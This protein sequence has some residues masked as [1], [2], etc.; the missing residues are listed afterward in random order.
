MFDA[1]IHRGQMPQEWI[2]IPWDDPD[3]SRRMLAEHLDQSL[4]LMELT[5]EGVV[6]WRP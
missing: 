2:K 4:A 3:F 5:E 6:A 1:L